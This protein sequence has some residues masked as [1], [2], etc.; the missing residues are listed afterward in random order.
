MRALL[1]DGSPPPDG[2]FAAADL[3]ATGALRVLRDAGLAV[4]H[5]VSLVGFDDAP[6]CRHTDP[7]LSTVRQPVE[8]MGA[9]MADLLL[10]RL[11]G[12]EVAPETVLPTTLVVRGSS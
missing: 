12:R 8:E 5:D 3:M 2:V 1:S 6:V 10:A 11:D 4:P 7:Q 9:V